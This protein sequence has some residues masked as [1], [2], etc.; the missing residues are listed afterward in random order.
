MRW[1]LVTLCALSCFAPMGQAADEGAGRAGFRP[2]LMRDF[3]GLNVHT[4]Q[5][6]PEL[7]KPVCRLVRDYHPVHWDLG[8]DTARALAFPMA[9]N[10][11]D[12]SKLYGAWTHD[13]YAVDACLMFESI[14]PGA[15]KDVA[16]D[17][18]AYGEAFARY[19]GP[20]GRQPWVASVE[21]GNEPADY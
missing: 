1:M 15:W 19:F 6:R 3:M 2:P 21:I 18:R 17:A 9:A 8:D 16:R 20:S 11:V 10:G 7:Y 12:W 4:V 13:G 5:F 14:K